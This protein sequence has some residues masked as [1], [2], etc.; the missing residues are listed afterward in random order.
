MLIPQRWPGRLK[1]FFLWEP[2]NV[3]SANMLLGI[4]KAELS[5]NIG[6]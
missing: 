3:P 1:I 2:A 6:R 5:S 4:F